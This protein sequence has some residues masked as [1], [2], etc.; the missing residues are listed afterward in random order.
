MCYQTDGK[1]AAGGFLQFE[2]VTTLHHALRNNVSLWVGLVVGIGRIS[3]DGAVVLA[4]LFKKVE[5]D[6]SLVT[7]LVTLAANEPV[8]RAFGLA[9]YGDVVGM[10]WSQSQATSRINWKASSKRS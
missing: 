8:L 2:G 5:F 1:T 7:V 4:S 3:I 6:G 10:L 9:S